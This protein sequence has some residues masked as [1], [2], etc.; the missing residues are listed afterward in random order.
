LYEKAMREKVNHDYQVRSCR[1]VARGVAAV[2]LALCIPVLLV[3]VI[4]TVEACNIVFLKQ[5][6][7]TAAYEGA[8]TAIGSGATTADVE[9]Q[10]QQILKERKVASGSITV[11][12]PI[13][14][15]VPVGQYITVAVSAPAD[16]NAVLK[17]WFYNGQTL[18]G[19]ATMM[20][21]F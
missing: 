14:S 9:N 17:G 6:L 1:R 13:V 2:E 5:S 11:N 18:Q 8:R 20:K 19:Q 3:L 4:G 21:E 7:T 16:S 15:D 12:P 10:C